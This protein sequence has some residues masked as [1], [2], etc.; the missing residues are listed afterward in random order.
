M[1]GSA[2]TDT[3]ERGDLRRLPGCRPRRRRAGAEGGG[4]PLPALQAVFTTAVLPNGWSDTDAQAAL[5]EKH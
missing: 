1:D 5:K 4:A 3:A 2:P